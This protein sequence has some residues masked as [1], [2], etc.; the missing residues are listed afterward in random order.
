MFSAIARPQVR[1]IPPGIDT[2]F[3]NIF[4]PI[5]AL[6]W[7]RNPA[8]EARAIVGYWATH[9]PYKRWVEIFVFSRPPQFSRPPNL[10]FFASARAY[11]DAL[12]TLVTSNENVSSLL[13]TL[14][15][16]VVSSRSFLYRC[17]AVGQ[18]CFIDA[19]DT[20][21]PLPADQAHWFGAGGALSVTALI[22]VS[23]ALARDDEEAR[24]FAL[25]TKY[26][27]QEAE[28]TIPALLG[29]AATLAVPEVPVLS[30]KTPHPLV[31]LLAKQKKRKRGKEEE[32][33]VRESVE[34][35]PVIERKR[36]AKRARRMDDFLYY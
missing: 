28:P 9:V 16:T 31:R 3:C 27:E 13:P 36:T 5:D 33:E 14:A 20:F 17:L 30:A 24:R 7:E 4:S 32:E 12:W 2:L 34:E 21:P 6:R 10:P 19:T 1:S 35:V 23:R 22:H 26:H 29:L 18:L 8:A 11:A 15:W 25:Q